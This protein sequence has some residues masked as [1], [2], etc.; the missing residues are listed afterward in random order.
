MPNEVEYKLVLERFRKGRMDS[1]DNHIGIVTIKADSIED[2]LGALKAYQDGTL[3]SS[4]ISK[5]GIDVRSK[6]V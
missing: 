4:K 1:G 6:N 3:D 5:H 2:A